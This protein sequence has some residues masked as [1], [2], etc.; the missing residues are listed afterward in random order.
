MTNHLNEYDL[1]HALPTHVRL[2]RDMKID[3]LVID[4]E[5]LAYVNVDGNMIFFS[6]NHIEV[7]NLCYALTLLAPA[8][9]QWQCVYSNCLPIEARQ[10][11]LVKQKPAKDFDVFAR[12]ET[13]KECRQVFNCLTETLAPFFRQNAS[14]NYSRR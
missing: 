9:C 11:Y 8:M 7:Y 5:G 13:S 6:E 4:I 14:T 12:F 3:H 1:Y 2:H 10:T